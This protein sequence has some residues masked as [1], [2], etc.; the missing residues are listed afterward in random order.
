MAPPTTWLV[1]TPSLE[2]SE[3]DVSVA[4]VPV[5]FVDVTDGSVVVD[6]T[7]GSGVVDVVDSDTV[8]VVDVVDVTDVTVVVSSA[9]T[10]S[11]RP[12]RPCAPGS[13][14]RPTLLLKYGLG[15]P[16]FPPVRL[17][18]SFPCSVMRRSS[19]MRLP[20]YPE[21]PPPGWSYEA[22]VPPP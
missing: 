5:A 3:S 10:I 21:P 9:H 14:P 6:A 7:D 19:S 4:F 18:P 11:T 20:T 8:D 13:P 16:L 22:V 17:E 1:G 15:A 2:V 12:C